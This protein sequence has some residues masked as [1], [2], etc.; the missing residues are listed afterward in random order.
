[1]A[2]LL[3]ADSYTF[4][5]TSRILRID[6]R[7]LRRCKELFRREGT[8]KPVKDSYQGGF[9]K[10]TTERLNR[11][12]QNLDQHLFGSTAEVCAFVERTLGVRD[13]P[14]GMVQMLHPL[15]YS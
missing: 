7:A 14:E 12:I 11:L 2:I 8:D 4:S 15:A 1:M 3:M 13:A 10:S 6:E 5:K 9:L